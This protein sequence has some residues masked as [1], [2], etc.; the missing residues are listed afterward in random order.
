VYMLK[1][2]LSYVN[3]KNGGVLIIINKY[4]IMIVTIVSCML[5]VGVY[6]VLWHID[7][8]EFLKLECESA[9]IL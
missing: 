9:Q 1:A 2:E 8:V 6:L 3:M 5:V 7:C 4:S